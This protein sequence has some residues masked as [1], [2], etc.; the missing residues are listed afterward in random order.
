MERLRPADLE[1]RDTA[2]LEVCA[3]LVAA[4]PPCAVSQNRARSPHNISV[5]WAFATATIRLGRM[6]LGRK[7]SGRVIEIRVRQQGFYQS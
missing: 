5:A 4:A 7:W 2:D 6:R 1:I 3:T